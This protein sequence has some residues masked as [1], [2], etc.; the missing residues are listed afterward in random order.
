[1]TILEKIINAIVYREQ[2][3][4][5]T[6]KN[7]CGHS[8]LLIIN[9]INLSMVFIFGKNQAKIFN[10]YRGVADCTL[11]T[12]LT[13]LLKLYNYQEFIKLLQ[14][15]KLRVTGDLKIIE[16]FL[17]TLA[18]DDME[19]DLGEYLSPWV[20]DIIAESIGQ[21]FYNR[22]KLMNYAMQRKKECLSQTI[23]EEWR[24][25]PGSIEMSWFIKEVEECLNILDIFDNRIH[26]LEIS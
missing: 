22:Y 2:T 26:L 9:E 18:L 16:V 13:T 14:D 23:I 24:L 1:M 7:L 17:M 25:S 8:L 20:G 5:S 6:Q 11:T 19:F 4:E 12:T 3:I 15:E 10:H 21:F